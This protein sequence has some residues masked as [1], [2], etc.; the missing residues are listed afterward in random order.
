MIPIIQKNSPIVSYLDN[1]VITQFKK[2]NNDKIANCILSLFDKYNIQ[3]F[4]I[5]DKLFIEVIGQGQFRKNIEKKNKKEILLQKNKLKSKIDPKGL[6]P[7][8]VI[9]DAYNFLQI[10]FNETIRQIFPQKSIYGIANTNL[11]KHSFHESY[12]LSIIIH[13]KIMEHA[14]TLSNDTKAYHNF[15]STLVTDSVI[16]YI[17]DIV[18]PNEKPPKQYKQLILH[19]ISYLLKKYASEDVLSDDIILIM[20]A[21]K[22]FVETKHRPNK[23][24]K[25]LIRTEDDFAD[26]EMAK[27]MFYGSEID[28]T[29]HPI[30][31]F[32]CEP[33]ETIETRINNQKAAIIEI[34]KNNSTDLQ[35]LKKD[36][37]VIL[38]GQTIAID[39]AL[40]N[41][42]IIDLEPH[43]TYGITIK[44]KTFS[45]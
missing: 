24:I 18:N 16:R 27:L 21:L 17:L 36:P 42:T 31:I 19:L 12:G 7:Q 44:K 39:T 6:V 9:E 13:N 23:E 15:I 35:C 22:Y 29:Q 40:L 2:Q 41:Y 10:L 43:D 4:L 32:S 34:A 8:G 28:G 30:T 37:R 45:F 20:S 1:S 33:L 25:K 11:K 3:D 14:K 26:S 5:T 38:I